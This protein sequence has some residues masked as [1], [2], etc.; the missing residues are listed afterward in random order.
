MLSVLRFGLR[1][2][3]GMMKFV[4]VVCSGM[5]SMLS[6][7][8]DWMMY[9]RDGQVWMLRLV[10]SGMTLSILMNGMQFVSLFV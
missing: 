5:V 4:F 7:Y 2:L 10:K 6:V 1:S 9:D 8:G 3:H